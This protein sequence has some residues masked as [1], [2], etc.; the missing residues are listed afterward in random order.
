MNRTQVFG[1]QFEPQVTRLLLLIH[2]KTGYKA[3]IRI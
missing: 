1:L 2:V 3:K